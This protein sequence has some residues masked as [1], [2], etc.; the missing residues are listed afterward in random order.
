MERPKLDAR[1][2]V[3]NRRVLAPSLGSSSRVVYEH[4]MK[5]PTFSLLAATALWIL[6]AAIRAEEAGNLIMNGGFEA[7]I[8]F[9]KGDGK[10]VRLPEGNRVGEIEAA[11]NRM[12]D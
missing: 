9:W 11:R 3:I 10:V 2:S 12:K 6:S 8:Q 4:D 5:L 1:G 7:G